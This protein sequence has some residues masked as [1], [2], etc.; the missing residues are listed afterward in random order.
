MLCYEFCAVFP[1]G[2]ENL[3]DVLELWLLWKLVN[4]GLML[5]KGIFKLPVELSPLDG[6]AAGFP[7]RHKIR[8]LIFQTRPGI[9]GEEGPR[10]D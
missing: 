7:L 1:R 3:L 9:L 5:L 2:R 6:I 8:D 4:I 10:H